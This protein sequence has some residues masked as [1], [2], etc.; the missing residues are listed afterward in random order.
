MNKNL[1][2]A[3]W[4]IAGL[5]GVFIIVII[6][7]ILLFPGERIRA[8]V[9]KEAS[10]ALKMPV[11]V[12]S[13]GLSFAGMP[14]VR[15]SDFTVGAVSGGEPQLFTVKTVKA[16]INIFAL[17]K[18]NIEIT[19]VTI[20][21]P[22]VTLITRK[23]GSSNLPSSSQKAEPTPAGPPSLPFPISMK[24]LSLHDGAITVDNR[25]AGTLLSV[26]DLS[27]QLSVDV[28][29]DLKNLRADGALKAGDI[30][31]GTGASGNP[32]LIEGLGISLVHIVTGDL[33]TGNLSLTKGD[34]VIGDMP[35]TLTANVTGWT[36][37]SFSL[38]TGTHEAEKMLALIPKAVFPE[39]D[40]VTARG[41]YALSVKGLV[42]TAP[43]KP[44][45]TFEGNLDVDSMSLSYKGLPKSIDEIMC[46]IAF[47][48]KDIF[49]RDIRTRIGG[50]RFALSGTIADYAGKP[51]LAVSAD[52][53]VDIGEVADALPQLAGSGLKGAVEFKLTVK[54]PPSDPKS[55]AITGGMNLKG[56]EV[57]IPK[58]LNHPALI[59]GK[60]TLSPSSVAIDRIVL[61]TGVSELAFTGTVTDYPVLIWPK[62]GVY[63]EFRG[64]VTSEL[65]DLVDMVY[66]DKTTPTPKPWQMEQAIKNAP[67]PPNLGAETS[68]RLGKVTFG[69]LISESVQGRVSIRDGVFRLS[70]LAMQAYKGT[71]AGNAALKLTPE[72]DAT[73]E[74]KFDLSGFQA[75]AFLSSFF[76]IS[77]DRFSGSLSSSLSFSGAGLDSV[78][79]LKNLTGQGMFSMENGSIKNWDFT[80][81]LGDT[82][83][84]LNFDTVDFDRIATSFRVADRHVFT[85]NLTANT[86]YGAFLCTGSVGFDTALD[87]DMVFRLNGKAAG[88]AKKNNIGQLADLFADET[89]TPVILIKT[90]GTLKSPS[91]AIDTSQA[92]AKAKDKL[93]DEANKMLDK[94]DENLKK[95]G[96]K[97]LKKLFK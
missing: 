46:R 41:T 23:D 68:I 82:I 27:Y 6:L 42:D 65:I 58:A 96:K 97:L 15:V 57:R 95:E 13:V 19:S 14:A 4:I 53:S 70:D 85:D 30:A 93:L 40:K 29:G 59:D 87:Y 64:A 86:E 80:K 5:A 78:S 10:S 25:K 34:M 77:E 79:M 18:K 21:E 33:T 38:S 66:I 84:F 48:E 62:K 45:I 76:G 3:L 83:K 92:K 89:G 81:K 31:F 12:G 44:V 47:T 90:G 63:A 69:K 55:V 73:Y 32:P 1:K 67:I 35:I 88:L 8:I 11:T 28:S 24:S 51:S 22:A 71:L 43:A 2:I 37:V 26:K 94:Q 56:I 7:A 54:G 61:K 17:L 52:G 39:K 16:R 49:L 9:E 74:S 50:S 36:R 72:G 60:I 91:F 75:G 20:D